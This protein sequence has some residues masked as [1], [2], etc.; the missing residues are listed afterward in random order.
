[1]KFSDIIIVNVVVLII[2]WIGIVKIVASVT[3]NVS[4]LL[5]QPR[6]AAGISI[7]NPQVMGGKTT[8]TN[9]KDPSP[10]LG[11]MFLNGTD[12]LTRFNP[13]NETYTKISYAG[14]RS[15]IPPYT[16]NLTINATERGNLSMIHQPS[17]ITTIVI[18][19]SLLTTKIN[20]NSEMKQE[21]ATALLVDLNGVRSDDPRS[22]TGVVFFKTNSTGQLAFLD[23]MIAI[24]QVKA[25]PVG[26]D[27]RMWQWNGADIQ[28]N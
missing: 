28:F 24:Y 13:I 5:I 21:N 6:D 17:G 7:G 20:E 9:F 16:T 4:F 8:L 11:R 25:S 15:I 1:M 18:G 23:N 3:T 2:V 19:Q 26:T 22:S 12:T 14:N 10:V 27:I